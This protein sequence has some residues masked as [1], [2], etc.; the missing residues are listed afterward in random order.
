LIDCFSKAAADRISQED[1]GKNLWMWLTQ[2]AGIAGYGKYYAAIMK[3]MTDG[4]DPEYVNQLFETHFWAPRTC[5]L[6]SGLKR[7]KDAMKK[8]AGPGDRM[9]VGTKKG[10]CAH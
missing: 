7:I 9:G 10:F 4:K 8:H 3:V 6:M 2:L 5:S 1:R